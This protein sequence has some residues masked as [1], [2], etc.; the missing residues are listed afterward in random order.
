MSERGGPELSATQLV[1]GG[2]ATATATVA[3]SFL[4]VGGTIAGAAF[5]SVATTAGAA[6]YK[7]YLDRGKTRT[8]TVVSTEIRQHR[9]GGSHREPG[10]PAEAGAT[11]VD[12]AHPAERTVSLQDPRE[13]TD[14]VA[15]ETRP[16]PADAAPATDAGR[17]AADA[18]PPVTEE[19]AAEGGAA[20]QGAAEQGA[21]DQGAEEGAA[22]ER[23]ASAEEPAP[24]A[25]PRRLRWYVLAG[26][27]V[28]VFAV[29]MGGVTLVEA[30]A[31]KPLSAMVGSSHRTGTS[32]GRAF[33]D[34]GPAPSPQPLVPSTSQAT[35]PASTQPSAVPSQPTSAPSQQPTTAPSTTPPTTPTTTLPVA[36]SL[37]APRTPAP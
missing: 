4:G 13:G 10:A 28:A 24:N 33:G 21:A 30:L 26:A 12:S 31:H 34:G 27:A 37:P 18:G 6:V 16:I 11:S 17:T 36:P 7:H 5:M 19:G 23:A 14:E 32:F 25:R 3:T 35:P 2:L 22:G 1:S 29:V 15:A 8:I 20:E 9:R